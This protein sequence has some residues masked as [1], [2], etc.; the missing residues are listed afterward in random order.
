TVGFSSEAGKDPLMQIAKENRGVFRFVP[1]G[2]GVR[3]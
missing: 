2:A 1:A 3:P